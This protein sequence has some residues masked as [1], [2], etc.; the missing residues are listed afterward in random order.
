LSTAIKNT[1]ISCT[2]FAIACLFSFNTAPNAK[3]AAPVPYMSAPTM[4][5]TYNIIPFEYRFD[6]QV[7]TVTIV[8]EPTSYSGPDLTMEMHAPSTNTTVS[9]DYDP[10]T[11]PYMYINISLIQSADFMSAPDG[12][13]NIHLIYSGPDGFSGTETATDVVIDT[14]T[15]PITANSP[16]EGQTVPT[17]PVDINLPENNL[18]SSTR[19]TLTNTE[20][21][22]VYTVIFSG[23][24]SIMCEIDPAQVYS[25]PCVDSITGPDGTTIPYGNYN[26]TFS[27]QDAAANPA[28]TYTVNNIT[29][30]PLATPTPSPTPSSTPSP[31][32]TPEPTLAPT[33]I[34]DNDITPTPTA[35]AVSSTATPT[36]VTSASSLETTGSNISTSSNIV[37]AIMAVGAISFVVISRRSKLK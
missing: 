7:D 36:T 13:Y 10:H 8:F 6:S 21:S 4:E 22:S 12:T 24:G 2:C 5:S 28:S 35:V 29:L 30:A 27:Y 25:S 33:S 19:M 3:A 14:V 16:A 26:I 17:I 11:N 9:F 15:Q 20:T 23:D 18:P 1:I 31:T 37:A 32:A 34:D